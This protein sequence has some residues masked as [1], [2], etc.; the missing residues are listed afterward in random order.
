MSYYYNTT[1]F[2]NMTDIVQMGTA[3]NS[4]SGDLFSFFLVIILWVIVFG[5]LQSNYE[6]SRTSVIGA[7]IFTLLV[8]IGLAGIGWLTNGT[9]LLW[10]I[11]LTTASLVVGILIKD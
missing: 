7:S 3:V 8:T 2:N 4:A 9:I 10:L 11:F 1:G 6:R 5:V